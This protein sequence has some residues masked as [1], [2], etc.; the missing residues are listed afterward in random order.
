[1]AAPAPFLGVVEEETAKVV[2]RRVLDVR[3]MPNFKAD[4]VV[5]KDDRRTDIFK[6]LCVNKP[7]VIS[8]YV[9]DAFL[10]NFLYQSDIKDMFVHSVVNMANARHGRTILQVSLGN[11]TVKV[12]LKCVGESIGVDKFETEEG[13]FTKTVTQQEVND[14]YNTLNPTTAIIENKNDLI[15]SLYPN[16]TNDKIYVDF[17]KNNLA[18]NYSLEILNTLGQV[19]FKSSNLEEKNSFDLSNLI[20]G[21]YFV[22]LVD[23]QLNAVNIKKI[24]LQ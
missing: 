22:R 7:C 12:I 13:V 1:M 16:P 14:L 9:T 2:A 24:I 18:S 23:A 21:I 17:Q 15:L 4:S 5:V 6:W 8:L 20:K 11:T 3:V 19:V 10:K